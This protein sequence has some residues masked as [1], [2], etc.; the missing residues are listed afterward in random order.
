ME[1]ACFHHQAIDRLGKG[2]VV[3]ARASDG[4]IEAIEDPTRPFLLGVQWHPE[5]ERSGALFEGFAA[6][7]AAAAWDA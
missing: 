6:A 1:V 4:T 3:S 5:T 7:C 2:L